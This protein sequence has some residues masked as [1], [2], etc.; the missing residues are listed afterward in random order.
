MFAADKHGAARVNQSDCGPWNADLVDIVMRPHRELRR[1][2]PKV[3]FQGTGGNDERTNMNARVKHRVQQSSL[4][5]KTKLPIGYLYP[6]FSKALRM[7][8]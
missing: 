7:I 1:E 2:P 6:L 3:R 4:S 5:H 8:F